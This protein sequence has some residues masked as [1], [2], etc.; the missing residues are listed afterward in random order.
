MINNQRYLH[1]VNIMPSSK[2]KN[3]IWEDI[4]NNLVLETEPPVKYIKDAVI[5]TRSGVSYRVSPT[6]YVDIVA[7]AKSVGPDNSDIY[8]C[9]LS[10]DFSKIKR[11]V[12]RWANKFIA[13]L[14]VGAI[15]EE[16]IIEVELEEEVKPKSSKKRLTKS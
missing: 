12:N 8:S 14:E 4:F 9:S 6:D 16:P 1:E 3:D 7:R 2:I 13:E 15:P 10:I 5:I 11:D